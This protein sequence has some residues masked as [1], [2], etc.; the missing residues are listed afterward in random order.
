[1]KEHQPPL[2]HQMSVLVQRFPEPRTMS[3]A[4]ASVANETLVTYMTELRRTEF[5]CNVFTDPAFGG[6]SSRLPHAFPE[7]TAIFRDRIFTQGMSFVIEIARG[8]YTQDRC[9]GWT[10]SVQWE[11]RGATAVPVASFRVFHTVF[12]DVHR[13][14]TISTDLVLEALIRSLRSSALF[15]LDYTLSPVQNPTVYITP[16]DWESCCEQSVVLYRH[17]PAQG[18]AAPGMSRAP[19]SSVLWQAFVA[20]RSGWRTAKEQ[21]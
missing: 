1:M 2:L 16:G 19:E 9:T 12:K 3:F 4:D 10:L 13:A 5:D 20:G 8:E 14:V 11:E 7:T 6:V 15:F 17:Q 18:N 21:L